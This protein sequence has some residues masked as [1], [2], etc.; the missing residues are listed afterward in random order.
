MEVGSVQ[1][2]DSCPL[3]DHIH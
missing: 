3:Y 1:G 2:N